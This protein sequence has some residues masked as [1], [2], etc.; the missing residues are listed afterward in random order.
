[1]KNIYEE[2]YR[3]KVRG[4]RGATACTENSGNA[5]IGAVK[6]LWLKMHEENAF[7]EEDLAA[8]IFSSTPDLSAAFP[9]AAVRALGWTNTPLFGAAEIEQPDAVK[10]CVRIL[11]LW[12]TD[13][14]QNE[15]KHVYLRE[16]AA[17]RPDIAGGRNK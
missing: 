17:L 4:V 13:K 3:M 7:A 9:A 6:E 14:E 11:A 15:I 8:V 10:R 12:N 2:A 1:L 5:I 16:A